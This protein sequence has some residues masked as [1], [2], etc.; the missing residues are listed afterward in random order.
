MKLRF[1]RTPADF[2]KWLEKHHGSDRELWVGYHKTGSGKASMTWPESVDEALCFG[3]IDGLRK[4]VDES[5]YR[6]RFSPRRPTSIWVSVSLPI[7]PERPKRVA[8]PSSVTAK[9]VTR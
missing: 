1:F 4:S 2:R 3:W 6:I 9:F 7:A 5:S 8:L